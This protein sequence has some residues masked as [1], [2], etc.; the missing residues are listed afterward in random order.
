MTII[1]SP[2]DTDQYKLTMQQAFFHQAP[3][4]VAE[5]RFVCR[6]KGVDLAKYSAEINDEISLFCQSVRFSSEE[7]E[8]LSH[9][10]DDYR[11]RLFRSDFLGFLEDFSFKRRYLSVRPSMDEK[12][13][14]EI[15][16]S[17]P[18]VQ[19]MPFEIY[20]LSIVNEIYFRNEFPSPDWNEARDRLS[21]KIEVARQAEPGFKFSDFGT[22]RRFSRVWHES[23]VA[24]LKDA[25]P[26]TFVGTSNM[27]LARRYKLVPVGTMAHE[28]LQA[29][30]ALGPRLIDSQKAALEAWVSEYRG[31]LGIALSDV[32]GV[33]AFIRDFDLYFAKLFDGVRHDSGNPI[34][35]AHKMLRHYDALR[36]DARSKNFIFS[37]GLDMPKAV[38]LHRMFKDKVNV[39]AGIGTNLTNDVGAKPINIV[40]KM[41]SCNGQPVAKISDEPGKTICRDH[42]FL[43][44]FRKVFR[45]PPLDY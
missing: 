32:A 11:G 27:D 33:D 30:Q 24:I 16:A 29:F 40:M 4:A 14:I 19:V 18:L 34:E 20:V 23:V 28:F 6:S 38:M 26:G 39:L 41:T 42:E 43:A 25:L 2:L 37:D 15:I 13:A 10:G 3:N 9:L 8:W 5:Y 1:S 22:R 45:L 17:G 44:Y 36:I 7:L 12:G 21:S 31:N 35:W